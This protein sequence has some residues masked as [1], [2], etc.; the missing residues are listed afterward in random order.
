VLARLNSV[1]R[2]DSVV[3]TNVDGLE[4]DASAEGSLP[5]DKVL[6]L[7]GRLYEVKCKGHTVP[8][9]MEM[10]LALAK[11]EPIDLSNCAKCNQDAALPNTGREHL[12]RPSANRQPHAPPMAFY[13]DV[14][15]TGLSDA[16]QKWFD[17]LFN[18]D[19][20]PDLVFI[21]GSSL[22][23]RDL[24]RALLGLTV[25]MYIVDT[26][27]SSHHRE[28]KTAT[29]IQT[30]AEEWAKRVNGHLDGLQNKSGS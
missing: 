2:L 17:E 19:R 3:S 29:I 15:D 13:E 24:K 25:P 4:T 28:L 30:T 6:R 20:I 22:R 18:G 9:T 16:D 21:I 11:Q 5:E 8:L 7:H 27:P 23:G 10:A 26:S 14:E 1:C 12:A